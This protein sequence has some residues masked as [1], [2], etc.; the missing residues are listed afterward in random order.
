METGENY[1]KVFEEG[2]EKIYECEEGVVIPEQAREQIA[3][4]VLSDEQIAQIQVKTHKINGKVLAVDSEGIELEG[5]GKYG[6]TEEVKGYRLY[7]TLTM[8]SGQDLLIGY[9][10]ADFVLEDDKIC[11]ILMVKEEVMEYIRVLIKSGDY[12]G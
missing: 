8:C 11:A 3:D 4:I 9:D 1:L 10:F 6:L 5:L 2:I 7:D 12:S